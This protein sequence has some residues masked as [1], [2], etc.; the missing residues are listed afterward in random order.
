VLGWPGTD[1]IDASF[2][3]DV[4][5]G[6]I[7]YH[8]TKA[9]AERLVRAWPGDLKTVVV[10]PTITY[11]PGDRDG[12]LT[13]LVG[14]VARGRFVRIGRGE[15]HFHLTYI[16]DL[17]RGLALAGTQPAA[18]GATFILAG[19]R[20]IAVRDLLALLARA[21]GLTPCALYLPETL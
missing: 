18:A 4:R 14:L 5:P 9:A 16:D 21:L 13:R 10:R 19:P 6:E 1:R 2:P 3:V 17:V 8:G 12:M 7:D 15:N 20:S 11:G